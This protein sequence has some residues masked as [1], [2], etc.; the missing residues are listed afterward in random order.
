MRLLLLVVEKTARWSVD[1]QRDE[2][3]AL[4]RI[5]YA[6]RNA[7]DRSSLMEASGCGGWSVL[8]PRA[9]GLTVVRLRV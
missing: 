4:N 7:F 5:A 6:H 3:L 9:E 1:E 2:L 8:G